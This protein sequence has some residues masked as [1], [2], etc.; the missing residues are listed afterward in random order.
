M[1]LICPGGEGVAF[2]FVACGSGLDIKVDKMS[3]ILLAR[4][5]LLNNMA[6]LCFNDGKIPI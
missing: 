6:F 5:S 3:R 1:G 2:S 4:N